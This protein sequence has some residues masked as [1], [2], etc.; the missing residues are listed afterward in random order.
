MKKKLAVQGSG[1][2]CPKWELKDRPRLSSIQARGLASVFKVLAKDACLR[3]PHAL[4]RAGEIQVTDLA[5]S[6]GASSL[7]GN[8]VC[9]QGKKSVREAGAGVS[10]EVLDE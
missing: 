7:F 2:C 6:M 9:A 3:L 8:K 1:G 10:V 5:S 4:V